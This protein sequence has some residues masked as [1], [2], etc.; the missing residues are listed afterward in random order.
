MRQ[1]SGYRL[2]HVA[3][4]VTVIVTVADILADGHAQALGT[5][6]QAAYQRKAG[7][8]YVFEDKG[9]AL[10]FELFEQGRQF[11]TGFDFATDAHKFALF[12]EQ[13]GE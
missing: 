1:R 5:V 13:A 4:V 10:L 12:F 3:G 11:K 7:A 9:L 6:E 8:L 2:L